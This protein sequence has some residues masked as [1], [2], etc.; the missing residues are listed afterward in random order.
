MLLSPSM[1]NYFKLLRFVGPHRRLFGV[2]VVFMMIAAGLEV[3]SYSLIVPIVDI[4]FTN[5]QIE[6]PNQLPAFLHQLVAQ[7]NA[8]DRHH[9]LYIVLIVFPAGLFI[10]NLAVFIY[11]YLMSDLAQRIM[12]DI[13]F[14]LYSKVQT[15]SLDYFS[16]RR[17]GE[18]LSRITNDASY[19]ENATSYAL[20]DLVRQSL[21]IVMCIGTALTLDLGAALFVFIIFPLIGY[22]MALIGKRLRKISSGTQEIMA[23]I[24]SLLMETI[25]GIRL[26]KAFGT[27]KMEMDRFDQQN[28]RYYRLRVKAIKR[29]VLISPFTEIVG[30]LL[31]TGLVYWYGQRI[32]SG[33]LSFGVFV[34]FI[35]VLLS[36]ISPVKKLG[37]VNAITQQALAANKRIYAVLDEEPS[38]KE[39]PQAKV[40]PEFHDKIQIIDADFTYNAPDAGV[41][42]KINMTVNKGEVVAV[43]GPTGVGKSTLVNLIPRF[44]DV[45]RGEV[46]FDGVNVRDAS[47]ASLRGQFSI[48]TQETILFNDTVRN[49]IA[50]GLSDVPLE[51]IRKAAQQAYADRFIDDL[52]KGYDTLIGDRG[53]RLSGGEKQRIA[54][55]RAILRN[56]PI[57]ILDEATSAL[58][59]E[60]EKF[61]QDA[62]DALMKGRTVI[63]IAHRLSTIRKAHKIVVIDKGSIVGIDR[64]DVLLKTCPLYAKLHGMQFA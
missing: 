15:L 46:I 64:H 16:E 55:A 30:G 13:R 17:T 3:F 14:Q 43:V 39:H 20:T 38:V 37:N 35:G 36:V 18:L 1:K 50:Y 25:S 31:A 34:L 44:Y 48:V 57:L 6:V 59:S 27:E 8:M 28:Q 53:F 40:L 42:K 22:P 24:N 45:T 61:V 19:V 33:E 11:Q 32:M 21:M 12:R 63:A 41:L 47:F 54:I 56:S 58:D 23:D 52:P 7:L 2:A 26:I 60:S 62:L 51:Q 10:K 29:L 9:L 5:K 49:N 4:I